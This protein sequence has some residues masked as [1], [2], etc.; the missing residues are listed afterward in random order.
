[1]LLPVITL[2]TGVGFL[3][4]VAF[5]FFA[6]VER[7]GN[8]LSGITA[9]VCGVLL[10]LVCF[11]PAQLEKDFTVT[12]LPITGEVS[13]SLC[14]VGVPLPTGAITQEDTYVITI[15]SGGNSAK[16][17]TAK[18]DVELALPNGGAASLVRHTKVYG[19]WADF[20]LFGNE[21]ETIVSYTLYT[22]E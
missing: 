22:S 19:D 10:V 21:T 3:S 14:G 7:E 8:A 4:L 15:I 12:D 1:M 11:A 13:Y 9:L 16:I 6:V 18:K 17:I 5:I 20:W 2:L